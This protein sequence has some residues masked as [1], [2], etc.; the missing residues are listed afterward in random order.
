ML[1][2]KGGL[3]QN[4]RVFNQIASQLMKLYSA[5]I[6]VKVDD[7]RQIYAF[8]LKDGV[9]INVLSDDG[10]YI[11]MVGFIPAPPHI[12]NAV[13]LSELLQFNHFSLHHPF[14][15]IGIDSEQEHKEISLHVRQPMS[16]LDNSAAFDLFE[17]VIDKSASL[18]TWLVENVA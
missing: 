9:K 1:I 8:E 4:N 18:Q 10:E 14:Y 2:Q 7:E 15:V 16:E 17:N 13:Y 5:E 12:M 11:Q 3:V 6:P